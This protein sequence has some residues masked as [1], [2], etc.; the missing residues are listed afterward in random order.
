MQ[1]L[2]ALPQPPTAVFCFNDLTAVGVMYALALGGVKV[3]T[4]CSVI[5]FD[6][7]ELATYFCPPLTTVRQP[8]RQMGE[9]A[10][11]MLLA[12]IEERGAPQAE[13]LPTEL[14]VRGTAGPVPPGNSSGKEVKRF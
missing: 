12:L 8:C 5:G 9:R 3:P 4:D 10:M 1:R 6:D 13:V 14:V 7:L 2:L 11:E